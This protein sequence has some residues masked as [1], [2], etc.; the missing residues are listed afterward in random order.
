[1]GDQRRTALKI[2]YG[3]PKRNI[4]FTL[5]FVS[6]GV[7]TPGAQRGGTMAKKSRFS[8]A[9]DAVKTVAGAALGAAAVAAT[10]VVV[11]KVAGAIRKSGQQ[12]EESTP[13]LQRFAATTVTKPLLPRR[14]KRA[15]ATRKAR[16]AKKSIAARKASSKR[17]IKDSCVEG[18]IDFTDDQRAT[19]EA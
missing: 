13:E 1:M 12:L 6:R 3:D 19:T 2:R 18:R 7:P 17:R 14:R 5:A 4:R 15:S 9:A 11:T 10:G 16:S 8:E